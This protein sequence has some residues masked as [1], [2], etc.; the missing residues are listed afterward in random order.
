[1]YSHLLCG[2]ACCFVCQTEG[3]W[4]YDIILFTNPRMGC[5]L[6]FSYQIF[7]CF[8]KVVSRYVYVVTSSKRGLKI[9]WC[10]EIDKFHLFGLFVFNAGS[11]QLSTRP[12]NFHPRTKIRCLSYSTGFEKRYRFCWLSQMPL[13]ISF[14]E[15]MVGFYDFIFVRRSFLGKRPSKN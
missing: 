11:R 10:G 9:N 5:K 15:E 6:K 13:S 4:R 1:M 7:W 2:Y 3:V 8:L 14:S 12:R